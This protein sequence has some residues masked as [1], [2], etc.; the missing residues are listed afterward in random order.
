MTSESSAVG[1]PRTAA[2]RRPLR[3]IFVLGDS[4]TYHGP[5]Q[6]ERPSDPRL[7]PQVMASELEATTG[8]PT[9]AD[10]AAG[11]GW[12]ARNGWWALTKDPRCWGELLPTAD[13]VVVAL[14][15]M[16][17]L[18]AAIPTYLR[19]GIAVVRPGSLRRIVRRSYRTCAPPVMRLTGGRIRQLPQ[20]ATDRYL[21]RI[22]SAVRIMRPG[23]PVLV[24][25][26]PPFRSRYYPTDAGHEPAQAAALAWAEREHVDLIDVDPLVWPGLRAGTA[27]PDGLHWG[28]DTHQAVGTAVA[29]HLLAQADDSA[30]EPR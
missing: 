14:G 16:D 22:V 17:H 19:E 23:I 25:S 24:L 28:W 3:R 20:A 12:T 4:L 5:D 7:W 2:G 30:F 15:G 26:P 8:E 9:T 6:A 10:L 13:A 21:S 18:P 27:N 11:L 29:A 1:N